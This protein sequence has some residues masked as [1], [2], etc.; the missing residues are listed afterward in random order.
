MR[1]E[2]AMIH[3]F[4]MSTCAF[5]EL[6][7]LRLVNSDTLH[8]HQGFRRR[9]SAHGRISRPTNYGKQDFKCGDGLDPHAQ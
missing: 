6:A 8:V 9:P 2:P 7:D 5:T 3:I 4:K 1:I